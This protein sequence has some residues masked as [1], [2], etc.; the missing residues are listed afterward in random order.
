MRR[1]IPS[2]VVWWLI[3]ALPVLLLLPTIRFQFLETGFRWLYIFLF[4]FSVTYALTPFVRS[5]AIKRNVLD[6]PNERKIHLVPT[7][8]L[9]G[10]AVYLGIL[11][12][13]G[14][15]A[16]MSEGMV[17]ILLAGT[18]MMVLG[19]IDDVKGLSAGVR[20]CVQL[21]AMAIVMLSGKVLTL[22][23]AGLIGSSLNVVLTVL[24]IIGITNALNFFDGMDGLATGLTAII[25]FFLGAVAFQ[26][27]Q[28]L[29]G[30]FAV[31]IVGSCL[32]FLPYN[33][34]PNQPAT[35]F[36]GDT[37]S[38]FLGFILACL[39]VKG[40]WAEGNPIV[41]LSNPILIFGVLI[42]DMVHI[43]AA[44]I[45][46]GKVAS[47]RSWIEY[48]G[49]DHLHH[50]LATLLGTKKGS[51]FL[52]YLLSVCLGLGAIMLR[53]ARTVDALLLLVQATIIVIVLS[54][55]EQKGRSRLHKQ[56]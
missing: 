10:L 9:G 25:A 22:F 47:F 54:I 27:H 45:I 4:S 55:L 24:W 44:R 48:V 17:A 43:T 56:G 40:N 36:L 31:A 18:L 30:W 1:F 8:L 14:A 41:S 20:L 51:V 32:G 38:S 19:L 26:T 49:K 42:Y 37:G 23:P 11:G 3:G 29:L 52:I 15:N 16:I 35:I 6:R 12:S 5:I 2:N 53:N 13:I 21:L 28:P 39:A 34:R 46:T 7:P 50:R 33:F